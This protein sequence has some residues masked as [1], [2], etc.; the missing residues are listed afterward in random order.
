MITWKARL[1]NLR[2]ALGRQPT[3]SEMLMAAEIH[4]MTPDERKAQAESWARSCKPTGD[5]R[6]D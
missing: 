2:I 1:E 6:F 5:P 3:L 4:E